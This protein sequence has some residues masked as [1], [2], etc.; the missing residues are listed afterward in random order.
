MREYPLGR[1]IYAEIV[2]QANVNLM[3]NLFHQGKVDVALDR[4]NAF[5]QESR[6]KDYDLFRQRWES[7]MNYLAAQIL[8]FRNELAEAQ[9]LIEEGIKS[10][11]ILHFKKREGGFLRLLGELQVRRDEPENAI[12]K[13]GESISM[14]EEVGNPRQLW[15][16]HASLASAYN[17]MGR[18]SEEQEQWGSATQIIHNT[19][20]GLSDRQLREGL[21]KAEPIRE[22][23]SKA[24]S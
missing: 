18:H 17:K 13:L 11:Q 14:L 5:K 24:E 1:Y 15:Q 23:F 6:S 3:E 9:A 7:R 8:L 20:N 21:L 4:M 16:A 12:A 10:A 2:S 22:I 19:A